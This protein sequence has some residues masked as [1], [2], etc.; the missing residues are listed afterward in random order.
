MKPILKVIYYAEQT[1]KPMI[2]RHPEILLTETK[3]ELNKEFQKTF[4]KEDHDSVD[5][6]IKIL[7]D[8]RD[9]LDFY[10]VILTKHSPDAY[11]VN[12]RKNNVWFSNKSLVNYMKM[13]TNFNDDMVKFR[14][15]EFP[16]TEAG[17]KDNNIYPI[18]TK[19]NLFKSKPRK[20]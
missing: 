6:Y 8:E 19:I 14:V 16:D 5:Y 9:K 10:L 1:K 17:D 7:Q 2:I 4:F 12:F 20:S 3:I 18:I 13:S 15:S 11:K